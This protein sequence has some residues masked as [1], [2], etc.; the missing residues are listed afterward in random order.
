MNQPNMPQGRK[1]AVLKIVSSAIQARER[2]DG[3]PFMV[4]HFI[5]NRC[6]CKCASCLWKDNDC[7]DVP[8][9]DLKRFYA[10]ASEEG[11]VA[12]AFSGGEPFLRKDLGELLRFIKEEAKMS[13]LLITTGWFL[14]QRMDET[15][16][17]VDMLVLSVDSAKAER[18]DEIRGLPGLFDRLVEGVRL[19]R[20][21][22][23]EL[24]IQLN[25]CVQQGVGS[26]V[27]DLIALAEDLGVRIS[28]DVITER[29]NGAEGSAHSETNCGMPL[30]ELQEVCTRL[31][32]KKRAGAPIIN[33]ERYFDY[34]VQ[35]RPG[36]TCHLPK[37]V[38]FVDGWGNAEYC[39]DLSKP[40]ANIRETP[41]K[42]IMEMGRFKELRCLAEGCSSCNSPTMVDLSHVWENPQLVFESGGITL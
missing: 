42:E 33:S 35:G 6:M 28:F 13:I 34:F 31:I 37:L 4:G 39:L 26:E 19:A 36:Y 5:T 23:P 40:I 21:R 9:E 14:K 12:T 11:F 17:H 29:R 10:S 22:Y 30:G 3:R 41:L 18:H 7:E 38:M 27:D 2:A 15:L 32:E 20:E 24:A 25:C 1:Q 8:L 16:P